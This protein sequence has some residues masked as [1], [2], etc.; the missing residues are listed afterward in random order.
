MMRVVCTGKNMV[1]SDALERYMAAKFGRLARYRPDLDEIAVELT[2]QATREVQDH[3]VCQ[4]NLI[5]RGRLILRGEE[6]AADP[7]VAIDTLVEELERSLQRQRERRE[8]RR[9]LTAGGHLPPAPPEALAGPSVLDTILDDFGVDPAVSGLLRAHGITTLE[10][11]RA[12][13]D[14]DRLAQRLGPGH[15]QAVRDLT[16][17]IEKLRL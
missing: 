16:Q 6:R 11:I 12:L 4:A 10:Q 14:D 1:L 3:Y 2:P 9:R 17:V 13:V 8:S 15:E 5:A 7:Y